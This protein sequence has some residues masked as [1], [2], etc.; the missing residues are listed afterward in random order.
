M[1]NIEHLTDEDKAEL[2]SLVEKHVYYTKSEYAQS[3]LNDWD[4]MLPYFIKVMPID[5]KKALE[6]I[7]IEQI[8]ESEL[9]TMT[10]EV[11]NG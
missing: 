7:K 2:K 4:E 8:K 5:Y 1:V 6:R 3:I 10:E 9:V 11:T